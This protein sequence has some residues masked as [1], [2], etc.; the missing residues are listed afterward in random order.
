VPFTSTLSKFSL[1]QVT[2]VNFPNT[3]FNRE[4][5]KWGSTKA[6]AQ[7]CSFVLPLDKGRCLNTFCLNISITAVQFLQRGGCR[8]DVA[9]LRM[10]S[11]DWWGKRGMNILRRGWKL[12]S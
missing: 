6:R 7:T 10:W 8:H 2:T 1:L 5:N 3:R 9:S 12:C 4:Q 11:Q